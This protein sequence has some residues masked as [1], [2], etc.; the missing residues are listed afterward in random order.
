MYLPY[1]RSF[2]RWFSSL[3][4]VLLTGCIADPD[5]SAKSD[6]AALEEAYR[7]QS[8][9]AQRT[10]AIREDAAIESL[11][12]SSA[13]DGTGLLLTAALD[14]ASRSK[15]LEKIFDHPDVSYLSPGIAIPGRVSARFYG[16]PLITSLNTLLS[17]TG[18]LARDED[19]IIK[20]ESAA[21]SSLANETGEDSSS[22]I[23]Q[24]V[25]LEHLVADDAVQLLTTLFE[26]DTEE[27][28]GAFAAEKIEELNALFISGPSN[29][30]AAAM[31]VIASADRPVAHVIIEALVVDIDT[32]SVESIGLSFSDG[33]DGNFSALKIV[34]GQ[35]GGNIVTTF[36]ELAS[37]SAQ[38]TATIDF[39]AAQN[40]AQIIARPYVS[41]RSAKAASIE[42]VS[43]QFARV[44]T[45]GDDSS[46]I[47]TDSVTAG[48][49][50]NI[51]PIVTGSDSIRLDV[52]LEES[53]FGIAAGDI[54]ITKDRST[55]STS[56]VVK[57][58]HTIVVGGLNSK[59]R[60]TEKS[61]LPWLRKVP[62]LNALTGDQGAIDTRQQLVVY[63]TPYIW[64]PSQDLPIPLQH[65]PDAVQHE[66]TSLERSVRIGD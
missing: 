38:V 54:I 59:Y 7:A 19:G 56:M 2:H 16:Q 23:S 66:P 37:N 20:I 62:I 42:I 51:T 8:V 10:R 27:S 4:L 35:T 17:G 11:L 31:Q 28:D 52:A 49:T 5:F 48:V 30:V 33:A 15:V 6:R 12:V 57:S 21:F 46:I 53:R 47:S 55:A 3:S 26:N 60:I 22:L 13:P 36:S 50:L 45:S 64:M 39:L 58:G 14:N 18:M 9:A 44:D 61:G 40:A 1:R 65:L 43:D 63:L 41:T 25:R 34:P 24:E 29:L 32:S